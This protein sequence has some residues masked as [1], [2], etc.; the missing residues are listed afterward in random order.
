MSEGRVSLWSIDGRE[1][2]TW[3]L[4][5]VRDCVLEKIDS[6]KARR[7][8]DKESLYKLVREVRV[9]VEGATTECGMSHE[10]VLVSWEE[11]R[12]LL[13]RFGS[14]VVVIA[15]VDSKLFVDITICDLLG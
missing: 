12:L 8:F 15:C 6:E 11:V 5:E 1:G 9:V 14:I 10:E 3:S 4:S 7:E 2:S 13:G